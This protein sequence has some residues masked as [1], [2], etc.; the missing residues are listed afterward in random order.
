MADAIDDLIT[1]LESFAGFQSLPLAAREI[2]QT[3]IDTRLRESL[4]KAAREARRYSENYKAQAETEA[5]LLLVE[6]PKRQ[7]RRK[8]GLSNR[9]KADYWNGMEQLLRGE[10]PRERN[11]TAHRPRA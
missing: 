4:E 1:Q 7:R 8:Q 11:Q 3:F 10:M 2:S 6:P 9:Q 5:V